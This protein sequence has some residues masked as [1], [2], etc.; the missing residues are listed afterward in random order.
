MWHVNPLT[1]ADPHEPLASS[2]GMPR[3]VEVAKGHFFVEGHVGLTP[4]LRRL[5]RLN[6][7]L[8]QA[9]LLCRLSYIMMTQ[10][11]TL[12][13]VGDPYYL[14]ILGFILSRIHRRPLVVK[15]AANYDAIYQTTGIPAYPRLLRKRRV[16]KR[17]ER[18]ILPRADLV[19]AANNNNFEYAL[20]NGARP[21]RSS[22]FRYGT[23]V[24]PSHFNPPKDERDFYS[25]LGVG[26]RPIAVVVGRLEPLKHPEDAVRALRRARVE[27]PDLCLVVVGDGSLREQV[28]SLVAQLRLNDA[29]VFAG[30]RDQDEVRAAMRQATVILAPLAGRALVEATLSGRPV[31]AY[32]NEW[33]SELIT[34]DESGI[35]IPYRD[36]EGLGAAVANLALDAERADRL[37]AAGRTRCLEMMSPDLLAA[38]ERDTYEALLTRR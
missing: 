9:A 28:A 20:A 1:G 16:E 26:G 15:V 38:H 17:I 3:T 2:Y 32:D 7:L 13:R 11:I 29:V 24:D 19:A 4:R 25:P 33:H 27:V 35:L 21:D 12:V 6:L 37:G 34:N 18:W 8:A 36:T 5:P 22:V 31:V 23:W 14:G 10:R 30:A